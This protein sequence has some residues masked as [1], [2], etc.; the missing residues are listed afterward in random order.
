M[1][2][3]QPNP[4]LAQTNEGDSVVIFYDPAHPDVSVLGEP[5][6]MLH[7]ETTFVG[8]AAIGLPTFIVIAWAFKESRKRAVT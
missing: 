7:N 1:Q 4:P 2:S 3:W 8:R 6:G 5:R